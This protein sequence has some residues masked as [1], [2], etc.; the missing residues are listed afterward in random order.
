MMASDGQRLSFD[1]KRVAP[2]EIGS[3]LLIALIFLLILTLGATSSMRTSN[4]ELHMAG[5]EEVRV[6]TLEMAQSIVD[7]VVTNRDNIIVSGGIGYVNC[8]TNVSG[9]SLNTVTVNP[10]LLPTAK[11]GNATV[12]VERLAPALTPAPR[13][14]NSSADAFFAARFEVDASYDGVA[15]NEGR[16]GIVQGVLVLVPRGAQTN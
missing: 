12:I 5:N 4:M 8:T 9:C 15:D 14:I 11:A 1:H 10:A 6:G 7:E 13:G 16:A 2:Q 3:V